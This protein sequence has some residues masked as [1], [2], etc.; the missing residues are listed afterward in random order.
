MVKTE[1]F[2]RQ[3]PVG[4]IAVT[5]SVVGLCLFSPDGKAQNC[6]NLT[7]NLDAAGM[8]LRRA[9]DTRDFDSAKFH[10]RLASD[11]LTDAA[12]AAGD[13]N[14]TAGASELSDA[15]GYAG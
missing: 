8:E 11:E 2:V 10:V 15:A 6:F 12:A 14:C 7:R 3:L 4:L 13:C 9:R 5:A 1:E